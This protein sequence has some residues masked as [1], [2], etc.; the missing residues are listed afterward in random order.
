MNNLRIDT[1][2]GFINQIN[3]IIEQEE[4]TEREATLSFCLILK[5]YKN[6]NLKELRAIINNCIENNNE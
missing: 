4:L 6:N 5:D 3:R 1:M 2:T